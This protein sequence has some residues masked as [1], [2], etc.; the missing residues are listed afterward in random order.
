MVL[1]DRAMPPP[2]SI[3]SDLSPGELRQHAKR[4][5]DPRVARRMLAIANALDGM[6]REASAKL[7]GMDRQA[8]RDWV[9]R[10][11]EAGLQGLSDRW[12]AGRP[13]AI[14]EGELA[15]VKSIILAAS[16]AGGDRDRPAWRIADV[17]E[18]IE[19]RTG[20][21]Y[22]RSGAHRLMR[23]MNLSHQKTR[24]IHPEADPR[25]QQAFKKSSRPR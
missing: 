8:L 1:E 25:A 13:P 15:V 14:E 4:E 9:I 12:G 24:P 17:A 23:S 5:K 18:L 20:V 22:S 7:A 21:R 11:N 3:R 16:S 10:Y 6:S 2:L 19:E